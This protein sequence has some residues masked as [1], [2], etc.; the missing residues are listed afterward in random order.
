MPKVTSMQHRDK[1]SELA[2]LI[3]GT[4]TVSGRTQED[5]ARSLGV[6][7][8][9]VSTLLKHPSDL[10]L[11]QLVKISKALDIPAD[12]IREKICFR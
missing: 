5:L 12:L 4:L 6:C 3:A 7:R 1:Q 11:E 8:K 10:S 9:T 2:V